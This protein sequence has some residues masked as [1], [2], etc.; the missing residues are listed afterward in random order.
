VSAAEEVFAIF[1]RRGAAAYLGEPV[2]VLEHCLQAA[3]FAQ[4]QRAP[5]ALIVAALLHDIGHLLEEVP[6]DI[7]DWTVDAHHEQIGAQWLARRFGAEV[8]EP[9]RL[10][11]P[12]KR[13]LCGSN[14]GYLSKLSAASLVTLKLQGGAMTASELAAFESERYYREAV[15]VRRCDDEGKVA[16]LKTADLRSYGALIDSL[17]NAAP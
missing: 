1:E 7:A 6:E 9:V 3:H 11:V 13:Y 16:G 5:P 4:L 10:H 2:S 12:A 17:A 8:T 14:P 15:R